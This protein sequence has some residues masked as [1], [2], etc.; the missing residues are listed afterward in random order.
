MNYIAVTD[1]D[2]TL[3]S[4][5]TTTD[6]KAN[7]VMLANVWLTNQTLPAMSLIPIAS[8]AD[9]QSAIVHAGSVIAQ[10]CANGLIYTAKE[11]GLMVKQ[12]RAGAVESEKRYYSSATSYTAGEEQASAILAYWLKTYGLQYAGVLMMTRL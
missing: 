3:G 9:Y 2:T 10:D 5:W 7:A 12:V 8:Q 11:T 6:K 1:V 4:T